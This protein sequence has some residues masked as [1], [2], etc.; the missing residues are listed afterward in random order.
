MRVWRPWLFV[1]LGGLALFFDGA[2]ECAR[3]AQAAGEPVRVTIEELE[4]GARPDQPYVELGP[5][6]ALLHAAVP[7]ERGPQRRFDGALYPVVSQQHDL[8]RTWRQLEARFSQPAAVPD[9]LL[10]RISY[11]NVFVLSRDFG[12]RAAIPRGYA[13]MPAVR[14]IALEGSDLHGQELA[15]LYDLMYG[16]GPTEVVVIEAGREPEGV[17]TGI[18][19]MFAGAIML[20]GALGLLRRQERRAGDEKPPQPA[21]ATPTSGV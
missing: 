14:G 18:V 11:V 10:P 17:M 21:F 8:A 12:S 13:T 6:L 3:A 7:I 1:G 9:Q 4:A 15:A 20:S 16:T 19:T 5:H 2:I